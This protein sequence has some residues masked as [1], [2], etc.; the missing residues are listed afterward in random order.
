MDVTELEELKEPSISTSATR[1]GQLPPLSDDLSEVKR[2]RWYHALLDCVPLFSTKRKRLI[3]LANAKASCEQA[4]GV[5]ETKE[6][7]IELKRDR[8]ETCMLAA[9]HSNKITEAVKFLKRK[10]FYHHQLEKVQIHK[11]NI[12][13]QIAGLEENHTNH[14]MFETMSNVSR[15]LKKVGGTQPIDQIEN[16]VDSLQELL[17]EVSDC[18]QALREEIS[19]PD[20]NDDE[21]LRQEI[22]DVMGTTPDLPPTPPSPIERKQGQGKTASLVDI[23]LFPE[24]PKEDPM[25]RVSERPLK[26]QRV[27]D[28]GVQ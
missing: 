23:P 22:M 26:S 4:L 27:R 21:L 6:K 9:M 2:L 19:Y 7:E 12:E 18:S 3:A 14:D 24:V 25:I 1:T 20:E 15:A 13:T 16:T 17:Q 28:R 11:F 8:Y 5:L 10:K